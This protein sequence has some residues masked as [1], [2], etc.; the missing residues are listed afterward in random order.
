MSSQ[1]D[2]GPRHAKPLPHF[3]QEGSD[4]T[5]TLRRLKKR[6]L[7]AEEVLLHVQQQKLEAAT[8]FLAA[9]AELKA[10]LKDSS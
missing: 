3:P 5:T 9:R 4:A 2:F 10:V 8:E 6:F 1:L 7:K